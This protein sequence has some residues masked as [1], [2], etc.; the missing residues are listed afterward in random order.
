MYIG[1]ATLLAT[2]DI[3][4]PLDENGKEYVPEFKLFGETVRYGSQ[5]QKGRPLILFFICS[6]VEPIEARV[7]PRSA[8]AVELLHGSL[9]NQ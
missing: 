6:G 2:C 9:S 8:Q 3:S 1:I 7:Q 4:K 5:S